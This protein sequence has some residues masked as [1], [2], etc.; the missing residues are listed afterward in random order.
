MMA[1]SSV[2]VC[3]IIGLSGPPGAGK[4]IFSLHFLLA[5]AKKGQKCVYINL[6]EPEENINKM[7]DEFEFKD[8]FLEYVKKGLIRK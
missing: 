7:I 5:G 1:L 8:E 2:F 3:G 4:S 6:E